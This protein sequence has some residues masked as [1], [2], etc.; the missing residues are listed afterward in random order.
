[1]DSKFSKIELSNAI[2]Y[3][4]NYKMQCCG[5]S[6]CFC[7]SGYRVWT[8]FLDLGFITER[9]EKFKIS[10][11]KSGHEKHES[12]R[13]IWHAK[14][15]FLCHICGAYSWSSMFDFSSVFLRRSQGRSSKYFMFLNKGYIF[16][17]SF[18]R[19]CSS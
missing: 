4:T 10:S 13:K 11:V 19:N 6:L 16:F 17:F 2:F 9:R 18:F 3:C 15:D 7:G 14:F 1:M 5:S 8:F 12:C